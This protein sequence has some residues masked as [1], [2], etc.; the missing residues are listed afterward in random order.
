FGDDVRVRIDG[1]D[2]EDC[3]TGLRAY[4]ASQVAVSGMFM[5]GSII[6]GIWSRDTSNVTL[7][8][9]QIIYNGG[10]SSSTAPYYGGVT[11]SSPGATID[12][13]DYPIS[14][15]NLLCGNRNP[16]TYQQIDTT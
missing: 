4:D 9:S 3:T 8:D 10:T 16:S 1:S 6:R 2:I 5:A 11:T 14:G 13:G 12:M 15:N 7:R